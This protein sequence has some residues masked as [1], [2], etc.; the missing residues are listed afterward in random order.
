MLKIIL[1][2]IF[3]LFFF[4]NFSHSAEKIVF[5]DI[6]YI[7]KNTNAGKELNLKI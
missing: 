6:N 7:F 3:F 2:Y 5:I 4:T 1:K